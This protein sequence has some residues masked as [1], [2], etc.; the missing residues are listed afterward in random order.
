MLKYLLIAFLA[1]APSTPKVTIKN[2]TFTVQFDK[3][4][5]WA[6][7]EYSIGEEKMYDNYQLSEESTWFTDH[8]ARECNPCTFHASIGYP[9]PSKTTPGVTEVDYVT[10]NT[11]TYHR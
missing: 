1:L 11:V 4:A 7:V 6:N 9:H 8:V 10:S 3:G 2:D 5:V